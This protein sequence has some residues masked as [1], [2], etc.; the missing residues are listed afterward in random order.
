ML[1]SQLIA[2]LQT[3]PQDLQVVYD[4]HS[5]FCLLKTDDIC[6]LEACRPRSDGWVHHSRPDKPSQKYLMLP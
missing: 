4:I 6:I 2:Y 1:V 5:E 3:Q